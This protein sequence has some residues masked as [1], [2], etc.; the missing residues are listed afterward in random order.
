[1][2]VHAS[3]W[4]ILDL[5]DFFDQLRGQMQIAR[6]GAFGVDVGIHP[7]DLIRGQ[8]QCVGNLC[9][10]ITGV[11]AVQTQVHLVVGQ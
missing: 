10:L 11:L 4:L 1:M 6:R 8:S 7:L 2:C 3:M 9:R 5:G